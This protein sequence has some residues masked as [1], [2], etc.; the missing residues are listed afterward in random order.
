MTSRLRFSWMMHREVAKS[1]D[2]SEAREFV[3]ALPKDAGWK[4]A[5][6]RGRYCAGS[7]MNFM[8]ME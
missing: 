5:H 6:R 3:P 4:P 1:G 7:G 2:L 8:R